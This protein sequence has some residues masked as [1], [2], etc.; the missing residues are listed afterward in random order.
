MIFILKEKDLLVNKK[1]TVLKDG[2]KFLLRKGS[3]LSS[4]YM[5]YVG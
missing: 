5:C 1:N 3:E 2:S 4:V